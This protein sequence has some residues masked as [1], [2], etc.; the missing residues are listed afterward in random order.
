MQGA[1]LFLVPFLDHR[2]RRLDDQE[3]RH[4]VEVRLHRISLG[5]PMLEVLLATI[6]HERE[7]HPTDGEH[8]GHEQQAHP[9]P[10]VFPGSTSKLSGLNRQESVALLCEHRP[11]TSTLHHLRR[12]AH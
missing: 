3:R 11:G 2:L 5:S 4:L 7:G 6:L 1:P 9:I 8:D 10:E 12:C